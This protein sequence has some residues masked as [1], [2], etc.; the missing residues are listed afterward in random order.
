MWDAQVP[1]ELGTSSAEAIVEELEG[2]SVRCQWRKPLRISC[3]LRDYHPFILFNNGE[4]SVDFT[5]CTLLSLEVQEALNKH[6]FTAPPPLVKEE[7]K[8]VEEKSSPVVE[9][10]HSWTPILSLSLSLGR[11]TS[12]DKPSSA[13][14]YLPFQVPPLPTRRRITQ[15]SIMLIGETI[16]HSKAQE[17]ITISVPFYCNSA[18]TFEVIGPNNAENCL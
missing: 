13:L 5:H 15:A 8:P 4:I 11:I 6:E 7:E 1:V 14:P 9:E 18:V 2:S 10:E 12:P 3:V 17:T 16:V